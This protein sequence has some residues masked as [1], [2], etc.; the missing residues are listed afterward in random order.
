MTLRKRPCVL[1]TRKQFPF[2]FFF[3]VGINRKKA[4]FTL[5]VAPKCHRKLLIFNDTKNAGEGKFPSNDLTDL[6]R[7]VT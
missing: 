6:A 5:A 4:K 2:S 1:N 7:T 3:F